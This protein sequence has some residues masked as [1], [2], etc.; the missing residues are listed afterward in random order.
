NNT[1]NYGATGLPVIAAGGGSLTIVGN[2]DII[3]RSTAKGTPPFRLLSVASGA[4]LTLQDL[5]LQGGLI[6]GTAATYP[7]R[8]A[9]GGGIL[10]LGTL[11][12]TGVTVQNNT[13]R[14]RDGVNPGEYGGHAF[15]GGIYS[16]GVLTVQDSIIRNNLAAGGQGGELGDGGSGFGGGLLVGGTATLLG[17]TIT[18]NAAK[19]GT[20]GQ[21][22]YWYWDIDA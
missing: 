12:L 13:A 17:T 5:T 19:G 16:G 21:G 1:D 10:S 18:G 11:T 20:G 9:S 2:G 8:T 7:E 22:S 14:G 3:E 4:S 15:G 6:S